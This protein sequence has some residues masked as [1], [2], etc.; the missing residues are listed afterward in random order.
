MADRRNAEVDAIRSFALFGICVVNLPFLALPMEAL[1]APPASAADAA[2]RFLV[3]VLFQGKF[4]VLFSFVFGWGFGIQ[5]TAAANRG[6]PAWPRYRAR[7]AGL[8]LIGVLHAVFVFAGDIL[9][10]YALLGLLLWTLRDAPAPRLLRLAAAALAV[11]FVALLALAILM[12]VLARTP[13]AE[14]AD[15]GFLG[16]FLAATGAR[17][18]MLS[19]AVPIV[20]LFN[21]PLAFACFCAGFAAQ[22]VGFFEPGSAAYARLRRSA[23][24]LAAVGLAASLISALASRGSLGEG[25]GAL[26]GYGLLAIGSPALGAAYLVGVVETVR[27][28]RFPEGLGAI[29]RMSLSAYVAQGVVAGLVFNGYGLG[30]YGQLGAAA[31]L[32]V[33][34]LIVA[35]VHLAAWLWL[36]A[37]TRGPLESLLRGFTRRFGGPRPSASS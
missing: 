26:F 25:L 29:G 24:W 20:L 8:F 37:F 16:G 5:M 15:P 23:P 32:G 27:R 12:T 34:V 28:G 30:L 7:L 11:A 17:V 35:A 21:G 9:M 1:L 2:A 3:E 36:R 33:A 10:L 19:I 22:R 14:P 18:Q 6:V 13:P 31:I 4:F